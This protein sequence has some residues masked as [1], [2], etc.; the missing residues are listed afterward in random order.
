MDEINLTDISE[1][2]EQFNVS[3]RTL[4]FYEEEGIIEHYHCDKCD[5]N[6]SANQAC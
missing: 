1:I 4:R 5:M 6:L 3:S 2:C